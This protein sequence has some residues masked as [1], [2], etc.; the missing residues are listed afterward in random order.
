MNSKQ[1]VTL[2]PS[3]WDSRTRPFAIDALEWDRAVRLVEET[4]YRP[5]THAGL[6]RND[7]RY[8]IGALK[9]AIQQGRAKERELPVLTSL[10]KFLEGPGAGGA[11]L[12]RGYKRWDRA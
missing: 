10:I 12:S 11:T 5:N 2:T 1:D 9:E 4:G 6:C 7:T 8:F 3:S